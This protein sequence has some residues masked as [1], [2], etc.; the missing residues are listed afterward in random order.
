MAK[1]APAPISVPGHSMLLPRCQQGFD[2][3]QALQRT[4]INPAS[5]HV[6]PRHQSLGHR[7][8]QQRCQLEGTR[9]A[10][11]EQLGVE[12]G[13]AT[14]GQVIGTGR[15]IM[16]QT[17]IKVEITARRVMGRVIDHHQM[18]QALERPFELGEVVVG[19]DI[20]IDHQ[21]RFVPQQGQCLE[22]PAAG[23]QRLALGE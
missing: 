23:F 11:L 17:L 10:P 20:A 1:P 3:R 22:D 12:H 19:P 15:G 2:L 4:D 18:S 14:E 8:P 5:Y 13:N 16:K 21:E 9:A 6:L 7:R